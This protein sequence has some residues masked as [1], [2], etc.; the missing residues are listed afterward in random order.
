[1]AG[2]LH[3]YEP[4]STE[5]SYLLAL[6]H[7]RLG[8]LKAAYDYSR[9]TGSRG[10][11]LGCAYV[12]AQACLGLEKYLEGVTALD[13]SRALWSSR[14]NWGMSCETIKSSSLAVLK[15]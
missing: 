9:H 7:L 2:R 4:K 15:S 5:A 11:H 1:M 10:T 8:Q 12:F 14:N 3:A 6:C 13:R